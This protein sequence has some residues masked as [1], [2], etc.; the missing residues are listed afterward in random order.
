MWLDSHAGFIVAAAPQWHATKRREIV[1]ELS[2]L[3]APYAN[4]AFEGGWGA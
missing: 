4:L 1:L 3:A 2:L